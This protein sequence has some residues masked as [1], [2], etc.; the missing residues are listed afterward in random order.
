MEIIQ[1][2]DLCFMCETWTNEHSDIN[3]TDYEYFAFH[4]KRKPRA[5]R[6]SVG[7]ILYIKSRYVNGIKLLSN[8]G[9]N[10]IWILLDK[11][12][13]GVDNPIIIAFCYLVPQSSSRNDILNINVFDELVDTMAH[14]NNVYSDNVSFMLFGDFNARTAVHPDYV[15]K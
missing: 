12:I 2:H 14:Y 8:V 5:K 4:R 15:E 9:D 13:F 3:F 7:I 10:I 11:D 1:S 6:D